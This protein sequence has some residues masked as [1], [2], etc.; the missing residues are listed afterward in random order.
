MVVLVVL[1][2]K[3]RVENHC[4]WNAS[5]YLMIP[6]LVMDKFMAR[7]FSEGSEETNKEEEDH[8]GEDSVWPDVISHP[9]G[10]VVGAEK[11]QAVY[12]NSEEQKDV[13]P[14][15]NDKEAA[16]HESLLTLPIDVFVIVEEEHVVQGYAYKRE[17]SSQQG[18][19]CELEDGQVAQQ[20]HMANEVLEDV[21]EELWLLVV[22]NF[23]HF[24]VISVPDVFVADRLQ[25][26]LIQ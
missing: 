13:G 7:G 25:N 12:L 23:D 1:I 8:M 17:P 9:F 20:H 6:L 21:S 3:V 5:N 18:V 14:Q 16:V 24:G 15:G 11:C 2:L 22:S 10:L 26:L 19:A 4:I